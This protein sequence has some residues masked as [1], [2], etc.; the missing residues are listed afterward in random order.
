MPDNNDLKIIAELSLKDVGFKEVIDARIDDLMRFEAQQNKV[1]KSIGTYSDEQLAS[2]SRLRQGYQDAGKAVDNLQKTVGK[3]ISVALDSASAMTNIRKLTDSIEGLRAK[4]IGLQGKLIEEKDILKVS[5][6]N[7]QIQSLQTEII[8]ATNAGR[9]GFDD[10]GRPMREQE[11]ILQRLQRQAQLYAKA[12]NEA[13]NQQ[14][15]VKYNQKLEATNLQIKQL[16]NQGKTGFDALGNAVVNTAGKTNVLNKSFSFLKTAAN[17]IPGIG[18]AGLFGLIGTAAYELGVQIF[19][20]GDAFN[21]LTDKLRLYDEVNKEANQ[22]AGKQI[23]DAKILYAGATNVKLSME[24]RLKAVKALKEEFPEYFGQIANEIILNGQAKDSYDKLY[25]SIIKLSR[26]KAVKSKLD[27]I[28]SQRLDIDTQKL[29]INNAVTNELARAKNTLGKGNAIVGGLAPTDAGAAGGLTKEQNQAIIRVRG[30]RA[31]AE[32]TKRLEQL[33]AEEKFL[34]DYAGDSLLD[35]VIGKPKK[36]ATTKAPKAAPENVYRQKLLE[37]KAK[38]EAIN[39]SVFTSEDTIRAKVDAEVAKGNAEYD[40]LFKEKKLTSPEVKSLK[41]LNST[42]G[43]AEIA[44]ELK[45]F[46]EKRKAAQKQIDDELEKLRADDVEKRIANIKGEFEQESALIQLEYQKQSKALQKSRADDIEKLKQDNKTGLISDQE[47]LEASSKLQDAYDKL[48]AD[49]DAYI[50]RKQAELSQKSFNRSVEGISRI[51]EGTQVLNSEGTTKKIN[52]LTD[53]YLRGETSYKHYQQALTDTLRE[54]SKK[55]I[56]L[57]LLEKKEQL[58]S[59]NNRLANP[60]T[61]D[62]KAFIDAQVARQRALRKAISDLE[63]QGA[64]A[65]AADKKAQDD[66]DL[67]RLSD[68][69]QAYVDIITPILNIWQA[70]NEAEAKSLDRSIA[71]QQ[72][73]VDAAQRIADR[74]NATYLKM[75]EDKMQDLRVKQEANARRQISINAA[76]Q[77]SS[78]LTA[79]ISGVAKAVITGNPL[80]AIAAVG[81]IIAAIGAGQQLVR[82]IQQNQVGFYEGTEDTGPGGNVDSKR[83][84]HAVL[85]P[86]ERVM[87]AEQNKK[88]RGISNEELVTVVEKSKLLVEQYRTPALPEVD[89]DRLEHAAHFHI[90][91]DGRLAAMMEEN[92]RKQESTL[93]EMRGMRKAL[94]DFG[95]H[96]NWDKN[97]VVASLVKGVEDARINK[98]V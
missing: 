92:N 68:Y 35:V 96:F 47:L 61:G 87:T 7:K 78:A 16:S 79:V 25:E 15:I 80:D 20:D 72:R 14:N 83:G 64:S 81:S 94:K 48:F 86:N 50:A 5:Q 19:R 49:L 91:Q 38:L 44:K 76:I 62:D 57:E 43:Q 37:L 17:L 8:R 67:A 74:G 21:F 54:E 6:Y 98:K 32:L 84:F 4:M 53:A 1:T 51:F 70:A 27:D 77:A 56:E 75:E 30:E 97:G 52:E 3:P 12:L 39:E 22:T 60:Q 41:A 28:E 93:A 90:T 11:G 63:R 13:T 23:E 42:I 65:D 73:R 59:V 24:E 10:M 95:F 58:S 26:A 89:Y 82:S 88:L 31:L 45:S 36:G 71:I 66:A 46:N 18:L 29:K 34:L 40:R 2:L 9:K 85:H 33:Q 55:R 69:I